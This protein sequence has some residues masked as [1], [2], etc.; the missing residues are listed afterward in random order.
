MGAGA[1][2]YRDDASMN[3]PSYRRRDG[4]PPNAFQRSCSSLYEL[5][6]I[7][8]ARLRFFS[9]HRKLG[10]DASMNSPS[11]RRRDRSAARSELEAICLYELAF[12]QK[13]RQPLRDE[14]RPPRICL[15]ELAFIQKASS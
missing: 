7:Q 13:A 5:A 4:A 10:W 12:I 11:Y 8:K 1:G 9:R 2:G 14:E 3:S 15:Y 6:F